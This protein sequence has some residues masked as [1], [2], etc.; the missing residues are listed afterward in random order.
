[1]EGEELWDIPAKK[2]IESRGN[3]RTN[4]IVVVW[5]NLMGW[6]WYIFSSSVKSTGIVRILPFVWI[7]TMKTV[8][9]ENEH[10]DEMNAMN[11]MVLARQYLVREV[12]K[13]LINDQQMV[14]EQNNANSRVQKKWQLREKI[15]RQKTIHK[16]M[17]DEHSK[18][19]VEGQ[20]KTELHDIVEVKWDVV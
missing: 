16:K 11:V 10:A 12:F 5:R 3:I 2:Q 1:M 20:V 18:Y 9:D 7:V 13:M 8:E 17:D 6:C 4:L 15:H 19:W 14:K